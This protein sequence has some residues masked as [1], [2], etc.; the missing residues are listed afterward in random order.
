MLQWFLMSRSDVTLAY[1]TNRYQCINCLLAFKWYNKAK[2]EALL[3]PPSDAFGS[4]F[5]R[6]LQTAQWRFC[7][8]I[9]KLPESGWGIATGSLV[10]LLLFPLFV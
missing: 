1:T 4:G 6:R 5:G 3:Q 8:V 7:E 10:F 2:P 9:E